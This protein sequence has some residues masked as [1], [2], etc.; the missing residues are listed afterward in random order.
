MVFDRCI[1]G[2]MEKGGG[3]FWQGDECLKS[4]AVAAGT[5]L[6]SGEGG[7]G[8]RFSKILHLKVNYSGRRQFSSIL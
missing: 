5:H 2:E 8:S 7:M 6:T 1:N 3:K 4:Q